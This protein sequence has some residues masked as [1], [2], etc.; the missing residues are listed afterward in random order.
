MIDN[1]TSIQVIFDSFDE[2]YDHLMDILDYWDGD[3]IFNDQ[4]NYLNEKWNKKRS[5]AEYQR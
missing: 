4:L 3:P 2:N 5:Q 1:E